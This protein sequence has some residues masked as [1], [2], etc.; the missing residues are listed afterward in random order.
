MLV[1]ILYSEYTYASILFWTSTWGTGSSVYQVIVIVWF[2]LLGLSFVAKVY[3]IH[4][5]C[6]TP[7]VCTA[8][9]H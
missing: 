9:A 1:Y 3:C 4:G 2:W 6:E 7:W 8:H 5:V